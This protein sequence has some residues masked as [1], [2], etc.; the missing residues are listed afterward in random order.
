MIRELN[1]NDY[2]MFLE[3]INKFRTTY[4][5]KEQFINLLKSQKIKDNIIYIYEIDGKIIGTVKLM[6]ETKF[7]FNISYVAHIED[8]FIDENYRNLNIGKKLVKH[9]IN[10]A[11]NKN[12]Y[13]IICVCLDNVK[14]FYLKCDFELRGNFMSQLL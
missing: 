9:C 1:I 11:K 12:C 10:I 7:I 5:T 3:L 13:K 8:I 6:I 2:S 14:K 4:F